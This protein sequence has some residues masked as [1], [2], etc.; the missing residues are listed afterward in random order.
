MSLRNLPRT[1]GLMLVAG[2]LV[3][4]GSN[5]WA[6]YA[7]NMTKGVTPV[8]EAAYDLH[9]LTLWICTI[10]GVLVFGVMIYSIFK[11]RKSKGAVPAQFHESATVEVIWTVLP[12]LILIG[13]AVPATRT[14][15]AEED[16]SNADLTIKITGYQWKWKYDYLDSGISFFSTLAQSSRDA[17]HGDPNSV[18]HYLL[19]VDN[20][21]VV[22]VH[23]KIRFVITSNDVI[24]SWWVPA[25]GFKQDAIPGFINDAWATIEKAGTY[26]GQCAELCG[27]DHGFMPIVLIAKDQ[28]DYDKWVADQKA[29]AAAEAE[30]AGK[31]WT[32]EELMAKGETLF[33]STCAACH[34]TNGQGIPGVFPALAGSKIATG[35]VAGHLHIVLNGKAGTAM[36]AFKDQLDDVKLAAIITYE[37]N[38]FGNNTGDV[39]QPSAVAAARK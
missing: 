30:S 37:R 12:F 34:Q 8:S 18:P 31:T 5:A 11:H 9:M 20:P 32:K 36:Q 33:N 38:A 39:V 26:R 10:V 22:P 15:L 29:A 17:V 19:D 35:P 1:L 4:A 14:L 3:G 27:K 16:T 25:L 13:I 21:I 24:H 2:T 6:D 28:A 7:L 23:K